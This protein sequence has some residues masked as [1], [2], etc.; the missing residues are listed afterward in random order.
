[1]VTSSFISSLFFLFNAESKWFRLIDR[2]WNN[3]GELLQ[4]GNK[5]PVHIVGVRIEPASQLHAGVKLVLAIVDKTLCSKIKTGGYELN[6]SLPQRI[7]DNGFILF[8]QYRTGRVHQVSS[9]G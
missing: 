6:V 5:E 2:G 7:V 4:F 1:M 8:G 9:S 3:V